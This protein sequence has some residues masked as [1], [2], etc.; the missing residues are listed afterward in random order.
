MTIKA[1]IWD[2]GGVLLRTE[3]YTPRLKLAKTCSLSLKELEY[4]VFDSGSGKKAQLGEITSEQH[5]R[6]VAAA[7]QMSKKS[8]PEIQ[9]L[10]WG[11]DRLDG[12]LLAYIR[13]LQKEYKTALLSNAFDDLR[14]MINGIW[15]IQDF[16]DEIVISS[17]AGL[18]KPDRRI[19]SLVLERLAIKPEHA[20]FIDDFQ[21]NIDGALKANMKALRFDSTPQIT[22]ALNERLRKP[23]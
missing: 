2:L 8:I 17:E 10:F 6:N 3:N 21:N 19:Y 18:M 1:I 13:E 4:L 22:S 11:G 7:L 12:A 23:R 15:K 5:W 14:E 9:Q 16:F 20:F